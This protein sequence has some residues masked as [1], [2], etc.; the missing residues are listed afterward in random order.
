MNL[1][2]REQSSGERGAHRRR[3]VRISPSATVI[4][5][6]STRSIGGG[7][8]ASIAQ[9]RLAASRRERDTSRMSIRD[10]FVLAATLGSGLIA[11][12]FFAFSTFVMRALARL[13]AANGL[14]AM[15]SINV[16]VINPLFMT[17]F[18]GTAALAA[19]L[20][21]VAIVGWDRPG[22]GWLLAA[23]LCYVVGTFGVTVV[24]NVPLNDTLAT[25]ALDAPDVA[26]RWAAYVDRWTLWNH[27]RTLAAALATIGFA[28]A[29]SA[30]ASASSV[31]RADSVSADR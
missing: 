16:V 18:L 13:P 23:A 20:A 4:A 5:M 12:V 30:P 6:T 15:Q 19:G 22:S 1:G 3:S 7:G 27:L 24:G 2:G 21:V 14:A 17:V 29:F 28:I 11:G 8:C 26:A 25:V 9:D 10:A 31:D